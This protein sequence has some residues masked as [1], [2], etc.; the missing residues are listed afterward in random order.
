MNKTKKNLL[1]SFFSILAGGWMILGLAS[2][3]KNGETVPPLTLNIK[4]EVFNLSPDVGPVNLYINLAPINTSPF[5][6]S[7]QQGYFYLP[8][9]DTPFQI[10]AANTL[11]TTILKRHDVLQSGARYT[12]YIL[13]TYL[14]NAMDT[15]LTVDTAV[16]PPNG[17]GGL[18]FVNVSPTAAAGLDV[19]ANNTLAISKIGY[20]QVSKYVSLP[21]GNYNL[22]VGPTGTTAVLSDQ[23]SVTIQN[24]RLYTLFSYGYSTTTDTAEFNTQMTTNQ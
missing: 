19:Y 17:Y 22:Q 9:I 21:A 14:N 18:R 20:K 10:R 23:P 3:S 6:F 24:G 11:G 12:L 8:S 13:G 1:I 16:T 2:C 4:Y 7:V 5:I 15:L